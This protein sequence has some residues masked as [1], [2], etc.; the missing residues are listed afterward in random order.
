VT[1]NKPPTPVSVFQFSGPRDLLE[2]LEDMTGRYLKEVDS[3][4]LAAL[5]AVLAWSL[6]DWVVKLHGAQLGFNSIKDFQDHIR[7]GEPVFDQLQGLGN[8]FKHG[9]EVNHPTL[10]RR[11]NE[12]RYFQDGYVT[13]GYVRNRLNIEDENGK[14]IDFA[15]ALQ[16]ALKFWQ[17]FFL[18]AGI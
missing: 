4:P 7:K 5:S 12:D 3:K 15:E 1:K 18:K 16:R 2:C 11:A 17:E 10:I 13:P 9:G 14:K 8:A 6:A